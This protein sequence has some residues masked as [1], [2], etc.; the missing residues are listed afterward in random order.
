M[1]ILKTTV[2]LASLAYAVLAAPISQAVASVPGVA[3]SNCTYQSRSELRFAWG[4]GFFWYR[5]TERVCLAT[6]TTQSQSRRP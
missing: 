2:V 5:W 3:A 6:T 4:K 1:K